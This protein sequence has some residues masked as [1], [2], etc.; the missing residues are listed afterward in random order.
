MFPRQHGAVEALPFTSKVSV[1][2]VLTREQQTPGA[3]QSLVGG[4]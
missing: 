2:G 3:R 1:A 4:E